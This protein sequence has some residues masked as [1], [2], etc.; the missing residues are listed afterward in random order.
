MLPFLSIFVDIP[1]RRGCLLSFGVLFISKTLTNL[2]WS[3]WFYA[4]HNTFNVHWLLGNFV[5]FKRERHRSQTE[6]D[7]NSWN[8]SE[9]RKPALLH[10]PRLPFVWKFVPRRTFTR[11][12]EESPLVMA[13]ATHKQIMSI[14]M[15]KHTHRQT[16]TDTDTDDVFFI[17]HKHTWSEEKSWNT[18]TLGKYD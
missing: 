16:N 5:P 7:K 4:V 14:V 2:R 6:T 18:G 3:R 13:R 10:Q 12:K 1:L 11:G 15:A 17:R 8:S 9:T